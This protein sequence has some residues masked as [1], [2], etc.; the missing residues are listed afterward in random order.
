MAAGST[1]KVDAPSSGIFLYDGRIFTGKYSSP[2]F[3]SLSYDEKRK[4]GKTRDGETD[5]NAKI[6]QNVAKMKR[7]RMKRAKTL[8][9]NIK[10]LQRKVSSLEAG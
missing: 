9:K 1:K 10:A 3:R 5:P 2:K 4:L 6:N 8:K 7:Q